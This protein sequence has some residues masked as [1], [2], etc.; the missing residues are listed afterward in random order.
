MRGMIAA[1]WSDGLTATEI[2][3]AVDCPIGSVYAYVSRHRDKCGYRMRRVRIGEEARRRMV[4]ARLAG[5]TLREIAE[6]EGCSLASAYNHC[7]SVPMRE[8]RAARAARG[9]V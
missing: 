3:A 2:A 5:D 7:R 1:L 4:E 6:R 9:N 8:S